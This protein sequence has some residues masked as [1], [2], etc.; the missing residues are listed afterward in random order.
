MSADDCSPGA[1]VS[2]Q[3]W[4]LQQDLQHHDATALP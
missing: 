1:R 4:K 3:T 2:P